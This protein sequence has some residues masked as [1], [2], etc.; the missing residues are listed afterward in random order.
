MSRLR[1][2]WLGHKSAKAG[3]GIITY[4]RE[5]TAG[6]RARGVDVIFFHHSPELVLD[7]GSVALDAVSLSHR[8]VISRPRA[9]RM[10]IDLLRHHDVDLVHASFS[11]SSLD[12]NLPR[13]CHELGLPIVATFHV[14]Y[15]SRFSVWGGISSALYRIYAQ[16]LDDC[17]GVVIFGDAQRELLVKLGVPKRVVRVLPNGVDVEKYR[18]GK[19]RK[20]ADLGADRIFSYIG[21]IDPEKNVDVLVRAFLEADPPPKLKL[22]IV[23]GGADRRR[24]ERRYKDAR[25]IFTGVITDEQ[26]RIAILRASDAFFLPSS[27]EGLS[28]AM[29]E[30]MA[31]GVATVA[32]DVG[33]DGSAL[34]GAG[35]VI[36]PEALHGELRVVIRQLV[37]MPELCRVLGRLARE[38]AVDRYSLSRNLDGLIQLYDE[39]V[40]A[41][42]VKSPAAR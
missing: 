9:K 19:S 7:D 40:E 15:D 23:G 12:F 22:V 10:L 13:V 5:I 3:D 8:I 17:D 26:E 6:L 14:P 36:D 35:V 18:P 37:E 33:N 41:A 11:F 28:L 24:I 38:R 25:V 20:L 29:L 31:C 1:V 39:L 27:V 30:A 2:A 34:R 32:T 42:R 16:A 21:R 4:S